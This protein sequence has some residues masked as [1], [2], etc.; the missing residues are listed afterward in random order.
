MSNESRYEVYVDGNEF[1]D[2]DL[3]EATSAEEAWE[4]VTDWLMDHSNEQLNEVHTGTANFEVA[5]TDTDDD[6]K[7]D[8]VFFVHPD[9]P[10]DADGEWE[11]LGRLNNIEYQACDSIDGEDR[12]YWIEDENN[13]ADFGGLAN[14]TYTQDTSMIPDEFILDE[15]EEEAPEYE[16]P[17]FLITVNGEE[18]DEDEVCRWEGIADLD[19]IED[20]DEM[21]DAVMAYIQQGHR[22][23]E[24]GTRFDIAVE[25]NED[26]EDTADGW[27]EF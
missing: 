7:F 5:V 14:R 12:W 3:S 19:D 16:E 15:E 26:E 25:S 21:L 17:R 27:V 11:Y 18:V 2:V 24:D 6:S 1:N 20:A 9:E 8:Q 23:N 10:E 13:P 4:L 22:G